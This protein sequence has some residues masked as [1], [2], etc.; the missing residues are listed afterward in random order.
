M[1]YK[2]FYLNERAVKIILSVSLM[3]P[4]KFLRWFTECI[5]EPGVEFPCVETEVTF[6]IDSFWISNDVDKNGFDVEHL[7]Y[8]D[9]ME[10]TDVFFDIPKNI[11]LGDYNLKSPLRLFTL[12]NKCTTVCETFIHMFTK[13]F[14]NEAFTKLVEMPE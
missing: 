6:D 4:E 13:I 10:L 9:F 8:I 1:K 14:E 5:E 3:T 7:K 11:H 12:C 2:G